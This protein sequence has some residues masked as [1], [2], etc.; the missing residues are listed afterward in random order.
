MDAGVHSRSRS[1]SFLLPGARAVP[2]Y[3]RHHR[4]VRVIDGKRISGVARRRLAP[5]PS[6][7]T[8]RYALPSNTLLGASARVASRAYAP[9]CS[10]VP[11]VPTLR[12]VLRP[13][14]LPPRRRTREVRKRRTDS[15]A[16]LNRSRLD[17]DASPGGTAPRPSSGA[18]EA[19]SAPK[20]P[21]VSFSTL[22]ATVSRR[23]AREEDEE[24]DGSSSRRRA[25]SR[26][27]P[28]VAG[29]GRRSVGRARRRRRRGARGTRVRRHRVRPGRRGTTRRRSSAGVAAR[30]RAS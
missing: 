16:E 15:A 19:F 20:R 26:G 17:T 24:E 28:R 5:E 18:N 4:E 29:R 1:R 14:A 7:L 9:V 25:G 23:G 30:G 3:V 6:A 2:V 8:L 12:C 21:F 10:G 11:R 22:R 27:G 13:D